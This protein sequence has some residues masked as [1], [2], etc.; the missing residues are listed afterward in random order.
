MMDLLLVIIRLW[1]ES[2]WYAI[3]IAWIDVQIWYLERT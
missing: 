1:L 2:R 3:K